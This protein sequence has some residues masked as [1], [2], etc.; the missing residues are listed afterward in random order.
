MIG[1]GVEKDQQT[2]RTPPVIDENPK[3]FGGDGASVIAPLFT[4]FYFLILVASFASS[5][6]FLQSPFQ[7]FFNI[8][9]V[10]TVVSWN[11]LC[12]MISFLVSSPIHLF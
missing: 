5:V 11:P 2:T 3:R 6:L 4:V 9:V 7:A 10:N 12:F 1:V 8:G